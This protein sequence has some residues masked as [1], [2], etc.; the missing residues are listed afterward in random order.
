MVGPPEPAYVAPRSGLA[1][2]QIT[3]DEPP[4][5]IHLSLAIEGVE[6]PGSKL[7]GS[8][9]ASYWTSD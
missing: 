3:G 8:R 7:F 4:R 5:R 6:P 1:K 2:E 9:A